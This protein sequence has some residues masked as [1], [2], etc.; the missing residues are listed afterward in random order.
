M[1]LDTAR[2]GKDSD[3]LNIYKIRSN[4]GNAGAEVTGA[5]GFVEIKNQRCAAG[6]APIINAP[7]RV[8]NCQ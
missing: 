6:C 7:R 5:A 8:V 4:T 2:S 1:I 3:M